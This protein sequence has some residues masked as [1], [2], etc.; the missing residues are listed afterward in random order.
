[1]I[2]VML[3]ALLTASVFSLSFTLTVLALSDF[4]VGCPTVEVPVC[5]R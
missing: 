4:G 5:C 2:P 3:A 1:M